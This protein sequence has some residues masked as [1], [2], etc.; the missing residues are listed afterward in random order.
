MSDACHLVGAC[1]QQLPVH[2]LDG[3]ALPGELRCQVIEQFRVGGALAEKA[4]VIDGTDDALA[5]MV[6]PDPIDHHSRHEG[7]RRI[8]HAPG[9]IEPAAAIEIGLLRCAAD[10]FQETPW[11]NLTEVLVTATDENAFVNWCGIR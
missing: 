11:H 7:T 5:E 4:E 9:Q 6:L 2:L 10:R 3:P 1:Q 8:E